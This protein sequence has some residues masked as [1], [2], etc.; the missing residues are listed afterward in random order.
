MRITVIGAGAVGRSVARELREKGHDITVV[1]RGATPARRESMADMTWVLGDAAE[2][3]TL[4]RARVDRSD[5]MV[6]ATGDDKV[7]L[8]VSLLAKTEFGVPR[9]VA[10][11]SHPSNE[12]M[13]DERWGVDVAVSTPRIMTALVEEAVSVGRVVKIFSFAGSR[14]QM[15]EITLPSRSPAVGRSVQEMTWPTGAV[16]VGIVRAGRPLAPAGGDVFSAHDELLFI[17]EHG[18]PEELQALLAPQCDRSDELP[19]QRSSTEL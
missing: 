4:Q 2:L 9:T 10:R 11:V 1:D 12:W 17:A 15:V 5:V 16:L 13:F 6:A 7:N 18:A 19:G 14:T 8:V 3:D